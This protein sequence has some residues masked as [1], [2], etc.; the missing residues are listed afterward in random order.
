MAMTVWEGFGEGRS[1]GFKFGGPLARLWKTPSTYLARP[2]DRC[3]TRCSHTPGSA[4]R[5][6][7]GEPASRGKGPGQRWHA[8]LG[9]AA[10]HLL[11][12]ESINGGINDDEAPLGLAPGLRHVP[13]VAEV[14]IHKGVAA[15]VQQVRGLHHGEVEGD[16]HA[17]APGPGT[18]LQQLLLDGG[19]GHGRCSLSLLLREVAA[20]SPGAFGEVQLLRALAYGGAELGG[21]GWSAAGPHEGCAGPRNQAHEKRRSHHPC[22]PPAQGLRALCSAAGSAKASRGR[23]IDA[24]MVT[25]AYTGR[26]GGP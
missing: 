13:G 23:R 3:Q 25:E 1:R 9:G 26:I 7:A 17:Q 18:P 4:V 5:P 2:D 11:A 21:A 14:A 15:G 24:K 22:P 6:G 10:S 19:C 8:A 20:A 12:V 16:G